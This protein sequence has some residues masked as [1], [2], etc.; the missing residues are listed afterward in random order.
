LAV[1]AIW[2]RLAARMLADCA[3]YGGYS[4]Y[5]GGPYYGVWW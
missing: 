4:F 1:R 3:Y 2:L 5:G